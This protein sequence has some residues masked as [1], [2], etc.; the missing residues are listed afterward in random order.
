[1]NRLA[2]QQVE[3]LPRKQVELWVLVAAGLG[4]KRLM[5]DGSLFGQRVEGPVDLA[6]VMGLEDELPCLQTNLSI[7][8]IA[9]PS[10]GYSSP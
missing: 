2:D 8:S 6:M 3:I 1:M 10:L 7:W 5:A 9:L 4:D